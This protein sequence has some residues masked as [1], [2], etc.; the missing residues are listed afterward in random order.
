MT[1]PMTAARPPAH[2]RRRRPTGS[3]PRTPAP[4]TEEG[5]CVNVVPGSP[6]WGRGRASRPSGYR[7]R[8]YYLPDDLHFRLRNAW[9]H[10]RT[11]SEHDSLSGLVAAALRPVVA[12]LEGRFNAGRPFPDL[13]PGAHLTPGPRPRQPRHVDVIS[14]GRSGRQRE[15]VHAAPRRTDEVATEAGVETDRRGERLVAATA[16]E[17]GGAHVHPAPSELDDGLRA[18]AQV[19]SPGRSSSLPEVRPQNREEIFRD[20]GDESHRM[21]PAG[22]S[23]RRRQHDDRKAGEDLRRRGPSAKDGGADPVEVPQGSGEQP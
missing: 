2:D 19:R 18:S 4:P 10:T 14:R 22:P 6:R 7:S 8:S 13:P 1:N 12:E 17:F 5:D 15:H 20:H 9:W 23:S 21:R 3:K 11:S 16:V